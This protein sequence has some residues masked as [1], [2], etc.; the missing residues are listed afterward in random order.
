MEP[1]EAP[2]VPSKLYKFTVAHEVQRWERSGENVLL[3]YSGATICIYIGPIGNW[4][5]D[6]SRPIKML[7]EIPCQR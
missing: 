7:L 5:A 6:N 2:L 1:T 4:A 3:H